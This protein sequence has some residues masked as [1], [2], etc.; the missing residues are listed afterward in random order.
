MKPEDPVG[1]EGAILDTQLGLGG[2]GPFE[3]RVRCG[4]GGWGQWKEPRLA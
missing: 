1:V 4:P 3:L 2:E